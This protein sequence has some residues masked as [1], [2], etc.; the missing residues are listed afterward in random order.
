MKRLSLFRLDC[1]IRGSEDF[2]SRRWLFMAGTSTGILTGAML[3]FFFRFT[4]EETKSLGT[5]RHRAYIADELVAYNLVQDSVGVGCGS[6]DLSVNEI[7]PRTLLI[8]RDICGNPV[9][10]GPP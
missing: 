4:C 6:P 9:R 2:D 5:L 8:G 3:V 1:L 10:V 7:E